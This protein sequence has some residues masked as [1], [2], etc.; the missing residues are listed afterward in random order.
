MPMS[1]STAV[2]DSSTHSPMLMRRVII[3]M[4]ELLPAGGCG[5]RCAGTAPARAA[6]A[7][8]RACRVVVRLYC[9]GT[10]QVAQEAL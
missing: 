9:S 8:T 6:A 7:R 2:A 4:L 3:T 1:S 10:G 5:A